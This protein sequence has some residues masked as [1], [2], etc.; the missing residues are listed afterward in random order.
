MLDSTIGEIASREVVISIG[1]VPFSPLFLIARLLRRGNDRAKT[2]EKE[3]Q[4]GKR[5]S[6]LFKLRLL[7]DRNAAEIG[8]LFDRQRFDNYFANYFQEDIDHETLVKR[9]REMEEMILSFF[10][11]DEETE[12]SS[13]ENIDDEYERRKG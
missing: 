8:D 7:Y 13:L 12:R 6:V 4:Q 10:V 3:C 2:R 9:A 11:E 1:K 5:D